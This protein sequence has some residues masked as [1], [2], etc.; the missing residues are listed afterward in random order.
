MG[1]KTAGCLGAS[2]PDSVPDADSDDTSAPGADADLDWTWCGLAQHETR[3]P[4]G[5]LI[6]YTGPARSAAKVASHLLP[7]TSAPYPAASPPRA[8]VPAA[9]R[10]RGGHQQ[11]GAG[12][13]WPPSITQE[14]GS[15]SRLDA[16]HVAESSQT[17]TLH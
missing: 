1:S 6:R 5:Q 9:I 12:N 11:P 8:A 4:R 15:P 14:T 16:R 17:M 13:Q 7:C 10:I 2:D 3:V